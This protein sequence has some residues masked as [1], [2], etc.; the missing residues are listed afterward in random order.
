MPNVGKKKYP[1]TAKGM[2]AAKKDAK[3]SGKKMT[4]T[5]KKYGK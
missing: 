4:M 2:A 1:Y 5:K 3:K